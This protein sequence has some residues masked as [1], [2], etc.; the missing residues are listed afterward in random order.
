MTVTGGQTA[1]V[2]FAVTCVPPVGS[3]QVTTAS[4]G[5]APESYTLLLDGNAQ[6]TV[7]ASTTRRCP[8]LPPESTPLV[9]PMCRPTAA[10]R[11]ATPSR[12]R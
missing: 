12:S 10:W 1:A 7:A 5:P 3:I 8:A 9:W 2:A 6:G 4:T 11:R